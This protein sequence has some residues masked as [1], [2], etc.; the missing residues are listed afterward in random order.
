MAFEAHAG[1]QQSLANPEGRYP[2]ELALQAGDSR[3]SAKGS[4]DRSLDY[5]GL[6]VDVALEGPGLKE[7]GQSLKLSLPVTPPYDIKGKVTH[8]ADAQRWNLVAI[9]GT[10]GDS[11]VGGD[12]SLELTSARPTV[13]ADLRSKRLDF[14]DL[15][16]VV[17]APPD[18]QPGETASAAQ[19]QQ[20]AAAEAR[21]HVLPD[22]PLSLPDLQA[23]DARIKFEGEKVQARMVPLEQLKLEATLQDGKLHIEPMRLEVAG[24]EL[25]AVI[26]LANSDPASR[27]ASI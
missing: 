9:R 17:G 5:R 24:G 21:P 8:E 22:K 16:V 19:R 6:D 3:A 2:I 4:V 15:G 13:V 12:I 18:T 1:D 10:I 23:V 26:D 11:D 25:E 27:A 20:A 7:L 14:D